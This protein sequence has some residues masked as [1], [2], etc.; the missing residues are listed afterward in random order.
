MIT[1]KVTSVYGKDINTDDIIPA[2]F[3]QQSTEKKFFAQYAFDRYDPAFRERCEQTTTNIVIAGDN[4]GCGSSREQ[5]VYALK[6]NNVVCVL[7]QSYPDIFYRNSLSNGLVLITLPDTSSIQL[8][9]ELQVDLDTYTIE[10][11]TQGTTLRFEMNPDDLETFKQGGMI[12]RVRTHL[13]EL[14]QAVK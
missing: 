9:D 1:G 7:A 3:L 10:N 13:A 2:S 5:A 4:F 12:G 8:G 11:V 14:L 6:E